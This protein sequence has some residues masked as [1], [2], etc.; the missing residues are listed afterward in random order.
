MISDI[1][2]RRTELIRPPMANLDLMFIVAA[3]AKPEPSP[4]LID[5]M[6]TVAD[7][8]GIEPVVVVTKADLSP[9]TSE[10]P[11]GNLQKMWLHRVR[12]GHRV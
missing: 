6:T 10:K 9:E 3:A 8:K 4:V 2:E 5:K 7:F 1:A 12:R 11:G